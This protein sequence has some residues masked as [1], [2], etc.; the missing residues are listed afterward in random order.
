MPKREYTKPQIGKTSSESINQKKSKISNWRLV[1]KG[2][3]SQ[4]RILELQEKSLN[5]TLEFQM[6][7]TKGK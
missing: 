6:V 4:K 5:K 7:A 2:K 3:V 1:V